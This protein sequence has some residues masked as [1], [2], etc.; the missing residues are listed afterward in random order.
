METNTITTTNAK[1][2]E[3]VTIVIRNLKIPIIKYEIDEN[4]N[5]VYHYENGY[6]TSYYVN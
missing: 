3:K 1:I 4:G 5:K 2:E 6:T